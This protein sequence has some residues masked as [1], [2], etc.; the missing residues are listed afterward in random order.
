VNI[1][2]INNYIKAEFYIKL[3]EIDGPCYLSHISKSVMTQDMSYKEIIIF[4]LYDVGQPEY[5]FA[6][7]RIDL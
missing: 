4:L 2:A 7:K 3:V 6:G 1:H 5:R